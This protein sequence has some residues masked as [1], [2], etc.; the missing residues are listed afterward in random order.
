MHRILHGRGV[1]IAED[2]LPGCNLRGTANGAQVLEGNRV[3][4][5]DGVRG[6]FGIGLL[7]GG[8]GQA[9]G[10]HAEA[11]RGHDELNR[12]AARGGVLVRGILIQ[13]GV[14][15][16]K[17]PFPAD[18]VAELQGALVLEMD[19]VRESGVLEGESRAGLGVPNQ[20][21]HQGIETAVVSGHNQLD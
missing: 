16:P 2:P 21:L 7:V 10:V 15:I 13:G 11:V 12:V 8:R 3:R 9:Q 5:A 18:Q 20:V 14:A 1:A 6:K 4:P 19:A 17:V